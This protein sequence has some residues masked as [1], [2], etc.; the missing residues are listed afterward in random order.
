ML[1]NI[2]VFWVGTI[3]ASVLLIYFIS[4]YINRLRFVRLLTRAPVLSSNAKIGDYVKVQGNITFPHDKTEFTQTDCSYF[5]TYVKA[6][7]RTKRKKP[8]KGYQEHERKIYQSSNINKPLMLSYSKFNIHVLFD[9]QKTLM[10]NFLEKT[11]STQSPPNEAIQQLAENK[12]RFYDI[13]EHYLPM[14]T[15]IFAMGFIV[16]INRGCITLSGSQSDK[17][18]TLIFRGA[19]IQL[20]KQYRQRAKKSLYFA[21]GQLG[22]ITLYWGYLAKFENLIFSASIIVLIIIASIIHAIASDF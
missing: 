8:A 16:D 4:K 7:F 15:A 14:D 6:R 12:F 3:T 5:K 13:V 2:I 17:H 10:L 22:L 18:P 21:F 9:N 20:L 1:F 19:F 11:Q